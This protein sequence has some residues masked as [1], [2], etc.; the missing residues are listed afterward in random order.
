[1]SNRASKGD[2]G[3][4]VHAVDGNPL[5]A[6]GLRSI[7]RPFPN[8]TFHSKM[9]ASLVSKTP[10]IFV[11]DAGTLTVPIAELL[12]NIRHDHPKASVIVLSAPCSGESLVELLFLGVAGVVPYDR[13][14]EELCDAIRS[15]AQGHV[16]I[17][18][19]ALEEFDRQSRLLANNKHHGALTDR[20]TTI[21]GLLARG[22]CNK[23][24][25]TMTGISVATVKFHLQNIFIK[26]GVHDRLRAVEWAKSQREFK[27]LEVGLNVR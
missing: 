14:K 9:P 17:A 26:I 8:V 19:G 7:L 13:A 3:I 1:M 5:A 2:K 12:R 4:A 21:L 15:V 23:E 6:D 11:V 27:N 24:I 20:E 25:A 16:W 18:T 10:P 22:F